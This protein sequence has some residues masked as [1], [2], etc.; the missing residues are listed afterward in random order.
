MDVN[1]QVLEAIASELKKAN[2]LRWTEL[3]L[4]QWEYHYTNKTMQWSRIHRWTSTQEN[5]STYAHRWE[6]TDVGR[7]P[8]HQF[9][10]LP[11]DVIG[12]ECVTWAQ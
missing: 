7:M 8:P 3:M 6:R 12:P 10:K 11:S 5:W 9:P 2:Q 1:T 4:N